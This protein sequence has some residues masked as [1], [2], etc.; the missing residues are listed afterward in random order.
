[1]KIWLYIL[2]FFISF[3]VKAEVL[4]Q[5]HRAE[6]IMVIEQEFDKCMLDF[7]EGTDSNVVMINITKD[8]IECVK[9]VADIIFDTFYSSTKEEKHK[10]F[11]K[12][13]EAVQEQNYN[14][15]IGSDIGK[16][17]HTSSFYELGVL[18][19]SYVAIHN[20]VKDYIKYMKSECDE[21]PDASINEMK[22]K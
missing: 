14:L 8:K 1:M 17:W 6:Q 13:M 11:G 21:I 9:N 10:Q 7:P 18:N 5:G 4:C 3:E 16:H 22:D 12:Y 20:M 15:E 19:R 2:C